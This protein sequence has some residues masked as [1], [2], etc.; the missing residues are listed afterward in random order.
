[1]EISIDKYLERIG[2]AGEARA[3]AATLDQLQSR[4]LMSVPYE[5]IDILRGIPLDLDLAALYDKIVLRGRGGYCFENNALFNWLLQRI[6]FETK[7]YFARFLL[8]EPEIPPRR[9]RVIRAWNPG[10]PEVSWLCDVGVGR[11]IPLYPMVIA[12]GYVREVRGVPYRMNFEP[13][14]G[15]VLSYR[16]EGVWQKIY[17]FTEEEQLEVDYGF[18]NFWCQHAP[19]SP[20]NKGYMAALRTPGGKRTLNGNLYREYHADRIEERVCDNGEIPEIL[21]DRF[22]ILV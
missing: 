21:R 2:F 9:H 15:W 6:G 18:A 7:S 8:D 10:E 20:F 4:H 16:W 5:N 12:E 17:S 14:F 11:E 19:E 13:F 3:D 22:G 1:M